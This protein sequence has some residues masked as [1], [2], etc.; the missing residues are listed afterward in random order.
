MQGWVCECGLVPLSVC[1]WGAD[2]VL[3]DG[4]GGLGATFP[5][6]VGSG[7]WS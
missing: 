4:V 3:L 7:P 5:G 2:W 6:R 1:V